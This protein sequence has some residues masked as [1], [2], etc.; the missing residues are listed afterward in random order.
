MFKVERIYCQS[1]FKTGSNEW[2]F[3]AREGEFGPYASK[4]IAQKALTG[5]IKHCIDN[6]DDG[7]RN[8]VNDTKLSLAPDNRFEA[9]KKQQQIAKSRSK[10]KGRWIY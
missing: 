6:A 2:F 1:N 7:G 4:A 3:V 9:H 5:M 8:Q 10:S